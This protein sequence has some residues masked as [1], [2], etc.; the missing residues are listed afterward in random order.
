MV[1][2]Q[3]IF[4]HPNPGVQSN[5]GFPGGSGVG[6]YHGT[7]LFLTCPGFVVQTVSLYNRR[8]CR[9]LRRVLMRER[10]KTRAVLR[11]RLVYNFGFRSSLQKNGHPG[12]GRR[13]V[14][15]QETM[16]SELVSYDFPLISLD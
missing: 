4:S 12:V 16:F 10:S 7:I 1:L 15:D 14:W 6:G 8:F 2:F 13:E 9:V 5:L 3:A 11:A